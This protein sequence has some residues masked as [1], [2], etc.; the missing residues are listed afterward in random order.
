MAKF[1]G[2]IGYVQNVEIRPG[3]YKEQVTERKYSGDLMR[4]V[5]LGTDLVL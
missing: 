4:L 5:F 1:Y 2:T 3:V